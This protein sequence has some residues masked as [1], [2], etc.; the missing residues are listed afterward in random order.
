M[1][2]NYCLG[3][4][5]VLFFCG[6][7]EGDASLG[8]NP[9]N[10][11]ATVIVRASPVGQPNCSPGGQLGFKLIFQDENGNYYQFPGNIV[12]NAAAFD[13]NILIALPKGHS[14]DGYLINDGF[15]N[16]CTYL[17]V[18]VTIKES[19][20]STESCAVVPL[21]VDERLELCCSPS[22][23]VRFSLGELCDGCVPITQ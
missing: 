16:N 2:V 4:L 13:H 21:Y 15:Q 9:N 19:I 20:S 3:L 18:T 23:D 14:Y 8:G 11:Y 7:C 1:N 6:G 17:D 22:A 12:E 10:C 5:I